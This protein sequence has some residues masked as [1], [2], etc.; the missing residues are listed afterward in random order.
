MD[1]ETGKL[2]VVATTA[3]GLVAWLAGL[4]AMLRAARE[5][6]EATLADADRF[7]PEADRSPGMVV[8][9][10]EVDGHPEDLAGKLTRLLAREGMG[11]F[12][13]VKITS[14]EGGVVA[15]EPAGPSTM[16]FRGG[17]I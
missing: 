12:G 14:A 6:R 9:G 7:D 1:P 16:G 2:V 11:P 15:F 5:W 3:I 8:G 13:P 10:D 4:A 17:R